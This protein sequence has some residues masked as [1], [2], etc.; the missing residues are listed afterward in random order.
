VR[1]ELQA[2][3]DRLAA[4]DPVF[5]AELTIGVV[6]E[7]FEVPEDAA[8]VRALMRG[9]RETVGGALEL[10]GEP[11][12][13]D[14]A[15]FSAAGVPTVLFGPH[16]VGEHGEEEWIDLDSLATFARVLTR[17]AY[18]FCGVRASATG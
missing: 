12:W 3:L 15:L 18:D 16:G 2:L 9:W 8:I 14:A 6:R 4:A 5:S 11:W 13:T 10:V 7:S 1:G 17:T